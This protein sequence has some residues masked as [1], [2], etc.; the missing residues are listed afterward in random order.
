MEKFCAALFEELK[1]FAE[2]HGMSLHMIHLNKKLLGVEKSN[3]FP[4]GLLGV[5]VYML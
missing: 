2:L 3:Q 1:T 4:Q 5:Y